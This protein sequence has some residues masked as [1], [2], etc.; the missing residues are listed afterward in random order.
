M[1]FCFWL[2]GFFKIFTNGRINNVVSTLTN[3][4]KFDVGNDKVV[5]TLSNV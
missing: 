5:Q 3:F 1:L 2:E 4:A